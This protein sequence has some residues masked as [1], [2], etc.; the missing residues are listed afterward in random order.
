[1]ARNTS[2]VRLLDMYRAECGL[3]LNPAHNNQLRD[4]QVHHLQTVQEWLWN[5]FSWPWL[6]V[7]RWILPQQGQ[8]YYSYP[9]D[10]D[11]DRTGMIEVYFNRAYVPMQ[12]GIDNVNYTAYNSELGVEQ[13]PP[14]RWR[15]AEDNTGEPGQLEIWPIPNRTTETRTSDGAI[16]IT[17]YRKLRPLVKDTDRA[18]LDDKLIVKFCAAEYLASKGSKNA[19]RKQQEANALF[20]KLRGHQMP[21]KKFAMFGIGTKSYKRPTERFP[22]AVFSPKS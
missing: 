10:L 8:R 18:E 1:M 7:E 3:S 21:R 13:W 12:P 19:D 15:I 5:E 11:I 2:L 4:H 9:D 20:A 17:G 16:K 6:R 22:I 14:Q